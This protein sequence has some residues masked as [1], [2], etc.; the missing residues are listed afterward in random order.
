MVE[1]PAIPTP[2]ATTNAPV[3]VLV[4]AMLDLTTTLLP[5]VALIADP[6]NTL[7]AIVEFPAMPTPPTTTSAPVV[8]LVEPTF[9]RTTTLLPVVA[10]IAEPND[11]LLAMVES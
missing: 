4:D 3:V 8:V 1:F 7:P 5:V 6:R 9:E 10:L 11:T 2:P